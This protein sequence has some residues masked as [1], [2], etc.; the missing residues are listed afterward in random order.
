MR[1]IIRKLKVHA[2][3][4]WAEA[5]VIAG[6]IPSVQ[7]LDTSESLPHRRIL[8][9]DQVIAIEFCEGDIWFVSLTDLKNA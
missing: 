6:E 2:T 1:K 4:K 5:K 9:G 8:D 3:N 7:I